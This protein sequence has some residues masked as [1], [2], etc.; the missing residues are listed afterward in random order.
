MMQGPARTSGR[1]G[2]RTTCATRRA[3]LEPTATWPPRCWG[4]RDG[5]CRLAAGARECCAAALGRW[6]LIRLGWAPGPALVG[7]RSHCPTE[8][9][10]PLAVRVEGG[11]TAAEPR[12]MPRAGGGAAMFVFAWQAPAMDRVR[13]T[14]HGVPSGPRPK[15]RGGGAGASSRRALRPPHAPRARRYS[16]RNG[17]NAARLQTAGAPSARPTRGRGDCSR[18]ECPCASPFVTLAR[19]ADLGQPGGTRPCW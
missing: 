11:P 1:P 8:S 9:G 16:R 2:W 3:G 10:E 15:N 5:A 4:A 7:G 18:L 6:G 14:L 13:R 12:A 17:S 19:R